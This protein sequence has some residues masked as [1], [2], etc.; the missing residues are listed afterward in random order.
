MMLDGNAIGRLISAIDSAVFT[1]L[2]TILSHPKFQRLEGSWRG[3]HYL[4]T[5]AMPNDGEPKN[6]LLRILVISVSKEDL[7]DDLI[8][9]AEFHQSELFDKVFRGGLC[10]RD[11]APFTVM[12]GDYAFSN[13]AEDI[14]LLSKISQV[15]AAS[16]C[17]FIG[18]AAPGLLGVPSW[19]ELVERLRATSAVPARMDD[20]TLSE[21]HFSSFDHPPPLEKSPDACGEVLTWKRWSWKEA[22]QRIIAIFGFRSSPAIGDV[23]A[24]CG[25]SDIISG[26]K[27]NRL[28]DDF[29]RTSEFEFP[30]WRD[31]RNS[32]ESQFVALTMPWVVAR[33]PYSSTAQIRVA[34]TCQ[35]P[36]ITGDGDTESKLCGSACWMNAAYVIGARLITSFR[37]YGIGTEIT[38]LEDG[39]RVDGLP[40]VDVADECRASTEILIDQ[41]CGDKLSTLGLISLQQLPGTNSA[42]V[43]TAQTTQSTTACCA[44]SLERGQNRHDVWAKY[45]VNLGT[46]LPSV[47]ALS[48]IVH[49][50]MIMARDKISSGLVATHCADFLER[51]LHEKY[52]GMP[53]IDYPSDNY[54]VIPHNTRVRWPLMGA[55]IKLRSSPTSPSSVVIDAQ[56][57]P[58]YSMTPP[59]HELTQYEQN[60]I[61]WNYLDKSADQI[62]FDEWL[63]ITPITPP[64]KIVVPVPDFPH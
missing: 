40:L 9:Q 27:G 63:K 7:F 3:L 54:A 61:C 53:L 8:Q 17:P 21:S 57:H 32:K 14:K 62:P 16:Y 5:T 26:N 42:V 25:P 22:A 64:M 34:P 37:E 36:E 20:A 56:L 51:W 46:R 1:Q 15:A 43:R 6:E 55:R 24:P 19:G 31:F 23:S 48:P 29:S 10:V 28:S 58:H 52:V 59:K 13:T 4:A 33:P 49:C 12:I 60:S 35:R 44:T 50:L 38:G 11:G 41:D 45:V 30:P 18:A 47:M 2:D 39:G